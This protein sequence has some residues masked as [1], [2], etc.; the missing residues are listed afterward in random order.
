MAAGYS[1][2][3]PRRGADATEKGVCPLRLFSVMAAWDGRV[4]GPG[5]GGRET[6][7]VAIHKLYGIKRALSWISGVLHPPLTKGDLGGFRWFFSWLL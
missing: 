3:R 2:H 6:A 4:A 7:S 5:G 1:L